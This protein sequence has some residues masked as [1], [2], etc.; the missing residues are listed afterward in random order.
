M[1]KEH[2][3]CF[4]KQEI[5]RSNL[6]PVYMYLEKSGAEEGRFRRFAVCGFE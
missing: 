4:Q 2:V 1:K 6:M 3:P 5:Y